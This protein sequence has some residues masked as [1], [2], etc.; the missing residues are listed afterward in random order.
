MPDWYK[1]DL[2]TYIQEISKKQTC[3]P[4]PNS[5]GN[6]RKYFSR[7]DE[8]CEACHLQNDFSIQFFRGYHNKTF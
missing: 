2:R 8:L 7:R 1:W 3:A 5:S 4:P 6:K